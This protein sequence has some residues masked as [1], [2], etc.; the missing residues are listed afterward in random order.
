MPVEKIINPSLCMWQSKLILSFRIWIYQ[1][2]G[3]KLTYKA[4]KIKAKKIEFEKWTETHK[5]Q[6][7]NSL[8]RISTK[9]GFVFDSL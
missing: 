4:D 2:E 5:L 7:N 8:P 1:K 3:K 6:K 9:N